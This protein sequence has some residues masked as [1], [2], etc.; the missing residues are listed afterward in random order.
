MSNEINLQLL[1]RHVEYLFFSLKKIKTV[2]FIQYGPCSIN[3][4]KFSKN[5]LLETLYVAI[6]HLILVTLVS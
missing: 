1:Y 2:K 3:G 6:G 5:S 4:P